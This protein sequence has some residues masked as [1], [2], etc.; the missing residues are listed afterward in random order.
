MALLM[1]APKDDNGPV[2][3]SYRLT[4]LFALVLTV[5]SALALTGCDGGSGNDAATAAP[6]VIAPGAPGERATTLS[7]EEAAKA[8]PDD[9]PNAADLTYVTNMIAHHQQ[10]L[11]MTALADSYAS[12][13]RV[14][15]LAGRIDAAQGPEIESMEAWLKTNGEGAH[16]PGHDHAAMPGMATAA[17][18]AALREARGAEFDRQFLSLMITHHRG[19]VTMA[20]D[21]LTQGRNVQVGEWAN[22]VIAQQSAE[23]AR[24]RAMG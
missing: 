9:T 20:T 13:K 24:M 14:R 11:A 1:Y 12:D 10:A 7:A 21:V 8:R 15:G 22:E 4:T 6:S 23:I 3:S 5:S 18:L 2:F 16:A 17:Q 19:A